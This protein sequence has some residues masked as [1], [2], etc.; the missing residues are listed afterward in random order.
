MSNSMP[1]WDPSQ[2]ENTQQL[3]EESTVAEEAPKDLLESETA[4]QPTGNPDEFLSMAHEVNSISGSV[5][6]NEAAGVTTETLLPQQSPDQSS[7]VG[8]L[9][10]PL[11]N[12]FGQFWENNSRIFVV[13]LALFLVPLPLIILTLSLLSVIN[14]IPLAAPIFKL[15]GI[16]YTAWFIY[17]YLLFDSKRQE[18]SVLTQKFFGGVKN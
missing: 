3:T 14:S 11:M 17:Q 7:G 18:L 12:T 5:H 16:S 2:P 1:E 15:I 9:L 8:E 13:A 6:S 10:A 4:Q